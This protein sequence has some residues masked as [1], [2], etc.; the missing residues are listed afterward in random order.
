MQNF[1]I[2]TR[3]LA[4]FCGATAQLIAD[5]RLIAD[6]A[7]AQASTRHI[8]RQLDAALAQSFPDCAAR[9]GAAPLYPVQTERTAA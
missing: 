1:A 3:A 9:N 5:M 7:R 8:A 2:Q 4:E 6:A